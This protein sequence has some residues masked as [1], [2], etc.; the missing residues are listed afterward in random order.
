MKLLLPLIKTRGAM[1][2]RLEMKVLKR[3][4]FGAQIKSAH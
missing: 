2:A 3:P 1:H 4:G